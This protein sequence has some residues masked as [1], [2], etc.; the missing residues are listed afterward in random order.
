MLDAVITVPIALV[1]SFAGVL[2]NR[3]ARAEHQRTLGRSGPVFLGFTRLLGD[4]R[5]PPGGDR[6]AGAA[7]FAVLVL[8]FE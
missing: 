6:H 5:L 4:D 7:V 3:R 1:L 8:V 2:L